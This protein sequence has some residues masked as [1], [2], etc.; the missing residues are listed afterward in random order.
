MKSPPHGGF[1][2]FQPLTPDFRPIATPIIPIFKNPKKPRT[3]GFAGRSDPRGGAFATPVLI[4]AN[5]IGRLSGFRFVHIIP[6]A[7]SA[8]RSPTRPIL[9]LEVSLFAPFRESATRSDTSRHG[10]RCEGRKNLQ[11]F[12]PPVKSGEAQLRGATAPTCVQPKAMLAPDNVWVS[13][14]RNKAGNQ[15]CNNAKSLAC[16]LLNPAER[17]PCNVAIFIRRSTTPSSF[18]PC[19]T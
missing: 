5:R 17:T 16:H 18:R 9:I 12:F 7:L 2:D 8:P 10:A 6:F 19:G 14:P 4:P 13:K 1:S 15:Q 11:V 3:A